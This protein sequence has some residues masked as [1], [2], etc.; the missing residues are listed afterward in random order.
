MRFRPLF[1]E[2]HGN[3]LKHQRPA[4]IPYSPTSS[5]N[6]SIASLT[7]SRLAGLGINESMQALSWGGLPVNMTMSVAGDRILMTCANSAPDIP[8]IELS[9]K[10]RSCVL[11]SN[12]DNASSAL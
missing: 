8:A 5:N 2:F 11:G 12:R 4:I 10:I 7:S 9:V 1:S 3:Y 6:L